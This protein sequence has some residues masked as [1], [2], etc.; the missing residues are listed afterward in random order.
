MGEQKAEMVWP[1]HAEVERLRAIADEKLRKWIELA[2]ETSMQLDRAEAEVERLRAERDK[3][4]ENRLALW[5]GE[6]D[7]RNRAIAAEREVER[8]REECKRRDD[9]LFEI[10]LLIAQY[11]E[12]IALSPED[13]E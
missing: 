5:R 2:Q 9:V 6:H 3:A 1:D 12:S 11:E 10:K 13:G 8:L 7:Q 4:N